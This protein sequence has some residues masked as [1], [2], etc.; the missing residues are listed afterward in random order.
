[1]ALVGNMIAT[2]TAG[3]SALVNYDIFVAVFGMLSLLYLL[4]SAFMES[5]NVPMVS[6]ALDALNVLFWFCAAVA[7][8]AYLGVHSCGNAAYTRTNQI[9]NGSPN[10]KKRC[11]EAQAAT[12]FLWFGWAA[13]VASLAFSAMSGRGNMNMRGGLRRGPSMSQV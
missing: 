2:S 7:T 4:P 3:N 1:M 10:T 8:A 11:H 12:A 9:T 6:I 5:F 13:F